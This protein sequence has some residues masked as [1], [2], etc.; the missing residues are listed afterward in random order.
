MTIKQ[1]SENQK[2]SISRMGQIVHELALQSPTDYVWDISPAKRARRMFTKV[3][4]AKIKNRCKKQGRK[5][6]V[7]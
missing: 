1:L 5:K 6:K 3:G 4:I 2:V 7:S